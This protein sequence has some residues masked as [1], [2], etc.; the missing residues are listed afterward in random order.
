MYNGDTHVLYWADVSSEIAFV[1]PTQSTLPLQN[2]STEDTSYGS[3]TSSGQSKYIIF[4]F[5]SNCTIKINRDCLCSAWYERSISES[6]VSRTQTIQ[7]SSQSSRTASLD[8]E[9]QPSSLPS[10]TE[11]VRPRRTTKYNPPIQTDTRIMVVWLECL[12]DHSQFP[13]GN[14]FI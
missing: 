3:D 7:S 8:L 6:G 14:L 9:K 13:I 10:S 5:F 1:V 4:L 11:N 12:E 2:D